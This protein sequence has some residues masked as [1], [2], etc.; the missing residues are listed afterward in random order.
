MSTPVDQATLVSDTI[1]PMRT[2]YTHG[3][4]LQ[5]RCAP[6][7]RLMLCEITN[8]WVIAWTGQNGLTERAPLTNVVNYRLA[9]EEKSEPKKDSSTGTAT[10]SRGSRTTTQ[11]SRKKG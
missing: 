1:V 7:L 9:E 4:K 8:E 11:G 5:R 6:D 3:T 10:A 2:G